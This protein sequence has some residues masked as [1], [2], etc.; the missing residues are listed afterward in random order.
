MTKCHKDVNGLIWSYFTLVNVSFIKCMNRFAQRQRQSSERLPF[1][2]SAAEVGIF[3]E[4]LVNTMSHNSL[5]VCSPGH[6][7]P[8]HITHCIYS[9]LSMYRSQVSSHNSR[10][11]P[12]SSPVKAM[13]GVSFVSANLT[14]VLS[15]K[16]LCCVHYRIMYNRDISRVYCI[17][18][19]DMV[20]GVTWERI[21]IIFAFSMLWL[22]YSATFLRKNLVL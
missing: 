13:Y 7:H 8:W 21:S 16:L 1:C 4:K 3:H 11:I 15:L 6:H 19:M 5:T 2:P 17:A 18:Y 22:R 20:P 9:A 14:E 10:K 12:H